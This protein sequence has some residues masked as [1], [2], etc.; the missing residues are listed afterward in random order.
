[1]PGLIITFRTYIKRA[2]ALKIIARRNLPA[3]LPRNIEHLH[4]PMNRMVALP[5]SL[6]TD[7]L[8]LPLLRSLDLS[9]NGIEHL[10]PGA[11]SGL[12]SL[13]KLNL[14]FNALTAVEDGGLEGL[15]RLEQ[16]DLRYNRIGQLHGRC[17]RPLRSLLD[18]SL[19]GNRLEVIR[20]DLFQDNAMLQRL[21]VSRNNLAQIPHSTF[22]YTRSVGPVLL[23]VS[24]LFV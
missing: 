17:L 7:A 23:G 24:I 22:S 5:A 4:L 18:L 12:P 16:L 21:D 6:G 3:G 13:R 2:R 20:P 14:G 9:A 8:A 11:L 15:G 10:P 1:M 19:R